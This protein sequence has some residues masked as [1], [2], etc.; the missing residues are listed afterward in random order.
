MSIKVVIKPSNQF[1]YGKSAKISGSLTLIVLR[2]GKRVTIITPDN[3][4]SIP[5]L[6][7]NL[8]YF[9]IDIKKKIAQKH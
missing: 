9:V 2:T 7:D 8:M 4:L 5:S 3:L 1:E 6:Q